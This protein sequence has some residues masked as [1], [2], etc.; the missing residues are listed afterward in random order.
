MSNFS[1]KVNTLY[2]LI[3]SGGWTYSS[4][5]IARIVLWGGTISRDTGYIFA[6]CILKNEVA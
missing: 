6:I 4:P 3:P 2:W 1:F 5:R